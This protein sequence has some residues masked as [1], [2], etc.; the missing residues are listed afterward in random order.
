[1]IL[2]AGISQRCMGSLGWKLGLKQ[3]EVWRK[4]G[5][6]AGCVEMREAFLVESGSIFGVSSCLAG[7][8][9]FLPLRQCFC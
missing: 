4:A 9:I 5:L 6:I 3:R 1:M 2:G 7:L 8:L